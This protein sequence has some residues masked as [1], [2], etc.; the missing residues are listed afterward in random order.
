MKTILT[1]LLSLIAASNLWAVQ[2]KM[3]D[4]LD[5]L[6]RTKSG[7]QPMKD[8]QAAKQSLSH[9]K[10]NKGFYRVEAL[11]LVNKAIAA[12]QAGDRITASKL[13]DEAIS[14]IEK[15]VKAG[16]DF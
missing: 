16:N 2:P 3:H 14:K 9:G 6:R 10:R 1:L 12:T 8:L 11:S 4:A 13:V 5:A 15:A 7:T